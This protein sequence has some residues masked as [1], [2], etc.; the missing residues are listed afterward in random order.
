MQKIEIQ[1]EEEKQLA[2]AENYMN[3]VRLMIVL[4][5]YVHV[6]VREIEPI[7]FTWPPAIVYNL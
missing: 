6:S 7:T 4:S 1:E 5:N 3:K 2:R